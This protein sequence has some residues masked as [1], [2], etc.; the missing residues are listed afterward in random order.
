MKMQINLGMSIIAASLAVLGCN[1]GARPV[2]QSSK[3][4]AV[5]QG[6]KQ[7]P[8]EPARTAEEEAEIKENLAQLSPEDRKLADAQ[9]YCAFEDDKRLGEMGVPYKLTIL[10]QPVFLC[11]K[12]CEMDAKKHPEKTLAK[13]KELKAKV[14]AETSKEKK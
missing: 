5:V 3:P 6:A 7:S 12:G 13:V 4:T 14:A 8:A 2:A 9:R 11:C 10:E 1:E